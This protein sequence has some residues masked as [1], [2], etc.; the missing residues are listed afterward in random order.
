VPR[1]L[2][3][4]T[5]NTLI[6]RVRVSTEE[7]RNIARNVASA[8]FWGCHSNEFRA[9]LIEEYVDLCLPYMMRAVSGQI[10]YDN[11]FSEDSPLSS[12]PPEAWSQLY[13]ICPYG[14][15]WDSEWGTI[16]FELHD[17]DLSIKHIERTGTVILDQCL[18]EF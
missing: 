13:G 17:D 1:S 6:D 2:L 12:S 11:L 3:C 4:L 10:D 15:L 14:H 16:H 8:G 18:C 5:P 7:L 9:Q